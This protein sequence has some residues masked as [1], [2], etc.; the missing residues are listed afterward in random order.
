MRTMQSVAAVLIGLV[1]IIV[2]ELG[3]DTVVRGLLPGAFDGGG[4]TDTW[5]MILLALVYV[6]ILRW[7][8]A[9]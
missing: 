3:A 8:A 2:L 5:S 6:G 7:S 9:T 1:A 4:G